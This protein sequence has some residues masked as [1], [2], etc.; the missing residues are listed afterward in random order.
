[1]TMA[2]IYQ[3]KTD[4]GR[5]RRNN[6]DAFYP[7]PKD[8]TVDPAGVA[9]AGR[10][11]IVADG[12]GGN[13]GGARASQIAVTRLPALYYG[14][15]NGDP[16]HGLRVAFNGV[17]HEIVAEAA[18][19]PDRANMSCTVVAVAVRDN[20][21]T[22][23]HLGDARVYLLRGG[24]L[25]P[26]T[27]DHTWVQMQV[28][29]GA[30]SA[31]EAEN[32]PDRNVI[33]KSMG[34]PAFPEPTMRQIALQEGDRLLLC[35]DGLCGLAT[36]AEIAAVLNR[37]PDPAAA[38]GPLIDLANRNGGTDNIT[39]LVVQAGRAAPAAAPRKSNAGLWVGL[40]TLLALLIAA[41]VLFR[42]GND[43]GGTPVA[44]AAATGAPE[45][46]GTTALVMGGAP[47]APTSTLAAESGA[48]AP[49]GTITTTTPAMTE[50]P[51]GV[52]AP[53]T[54]SAAAPVRPALLGPGALCRSGDP[55]PLLS[56]P[57]GASISLMWNQRGDSPPAD[58][59]QV[60]YGP[61][62]AS[63]A[64]PAGTLPRQDGTNWSIVI[65]GSQFSAPGTYMWQVY[66]TTT[67][68]RGASSDP[69]G[70]RGE[71]PAGAPAAAGPPPP[72]KQPTPTSAPE[73]SPT[74]KPPTEPS[75]TATL[76]PTEPTPTD[77]PIPRGTP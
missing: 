54:P 66:Y 15:T 8:G 6:E 42:P 20:A 57:P 14:A 41:F 56:I 45:R 30:L 62:S 59:W 60:R 22:I 40:L 50:T 52:I 44:E 1:M 27:T 76:P 46:L 31:A 43:T 69:W 11:F 7:D 3:G 48:G 61:G 17:A 67:G 49:A 65:D 13:R 70:F 5:A 47:G 16:N 12:V 63:N 28:E 34:N 58:Q 23:A 74:G 10:L 29:K 77:T 37:A 26:L 21:A 32:H 75:P 2:I 4:V 36:D 38:V 35:S 39:A 19:N 73:P 9:R 18:A 53:A 64:P 68:G 71:G 72:G 55:G 51:V 33:T 25:Q 24:M